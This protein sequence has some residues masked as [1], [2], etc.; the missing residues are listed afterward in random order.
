MVVI[1]SYT[2]MDLDKKKLVQ[3]AESKRKSQRGK[4]SVYRTEVSLEGVFD[5]E[6]KRKEGKE[7]NKGIN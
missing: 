2:P 7:R 1:N 5:E 3:A 4:K 6:K